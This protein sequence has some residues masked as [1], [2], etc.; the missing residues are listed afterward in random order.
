[1]KKYLTLILCIG[2]IISAPAQ[3][4]M[5]VWG[6]GYAMSVP[7]PDGWVATGDVKQ[8]DT[9]AMGLYQKGYNWDSSPAVMYAHL[10]LNQ[11]SLK[12]AVSQYISKAQM[13]CPTL[14][15]EKIDSHTK[16]FICNEGSSP[17]YRLVRFININRMN[18]LWILSSHSIDSLSASAPIFEEVSQSATLERKLVP[19][20]HRTYTVH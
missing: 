19:W 8:I 6:V 2:V 18:V 7:E 15:V 16:R 13:E 4:G 14:K 20:N 5:M 17:T 10:M 9:I 12:K 11:T 1:M 3:A